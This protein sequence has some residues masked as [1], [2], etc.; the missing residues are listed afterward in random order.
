MVTKDLQKSP[1][2]ICTYEEFHKYMGAWVRNTVNRISRKEKESHNGMCQHCQNSFKILEAA[3]VHGKGRKA[4]TY[5]VFNSFPEHNGLTQ[6]DLNDFE[7]RIINI[8]KPIED[9]FLFLCKECHKKYDKHQKIS[10]PVKRKVKEEKTGV[11]PIYLE[12]NDEISFRKKLLRHK[13][14]VIHIE[15]KRGHSEERVWAANSM[16]STSGIF[17]NLRSRP[18]FRQGEWQK[19]GIKE[20]HVKVI[21]N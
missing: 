20:V 4:L 21:E 8:H 19:R 9:T 6:I 1:K 12:P 2:F 3:H 16:K 17:A 15:Y 5:R 14:T 18:E 13:K 7:Q 11:L 10:V